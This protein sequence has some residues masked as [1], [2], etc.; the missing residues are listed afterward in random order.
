[1][2]FVIYEILIIVNFFLPPLSY[3]VYIQTINLLM[4]T[5]TNMRFKKLKR[6][7]NDDFGASNEFIEGLRIEQQEESIDYKAYNT[8]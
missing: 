5:T 4:N 1:M 2:K 7:F 8:Y 6:P 3:L